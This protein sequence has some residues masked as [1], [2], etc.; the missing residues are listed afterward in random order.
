MTARKRS[1]QPPHRFDPE[2][3]LKTLQR[4]ARRLAR[5]RPFNTG[6]PVE[7]LGER[8]ALISELEPSEAAGLQYEPIY[9]E[10]RLYLRGEAIG[11]ELE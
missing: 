6:L 10:L 11:G 9:P 7:Y 1:E 5:R 8:P 3:L 2:A 4:G